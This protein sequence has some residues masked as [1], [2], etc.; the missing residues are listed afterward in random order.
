MKTPFGHW[1]TCRFVQLACDAMN[2]GRK[3]TGRG[4]WEDVRE[5]YMNK[6]CEGSVR[7]PENC[8]YAMNDHLYPYLVSFAI[9]CE[10]KL[11]EFLKVKKRGA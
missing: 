3:Q 6:E 1:V 7:P 8:K 11:G 5:L 2:K 4:I 10:P 9:K